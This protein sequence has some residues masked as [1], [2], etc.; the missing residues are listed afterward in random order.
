MCVSPEEV[1]DFLEPELQTVVSC[2]VGA[3]LH[4]GSLVLLTSE[5]SSP[6]PEP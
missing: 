6:A 3:G 2:R 1:L 5:L 4:L